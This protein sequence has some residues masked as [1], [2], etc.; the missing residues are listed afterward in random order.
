MRKRNVKRHTKEWLRAYGSEERATWIRSRGCV[1]KHD[2]YFYTSQNVHVRTG[3]TRWK[4]DAIWIV[5]MCPECHRY[6]H[7][8]G[9]QTFERAYHIVLDE[10]ARATEAKWQAYLQQQGQA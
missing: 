4:A 1:N 10:A 2:Q 6:L 9:K 5:P 8:V 3:G 7:Q